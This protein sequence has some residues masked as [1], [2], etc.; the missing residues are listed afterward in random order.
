[1]GA[2]HHVIFK[3]NEGRVIFWEDRD[4][5]EFLKMLK[6]LTRRYRFINH[7]HLLIE[8]AHEP[9]RDYSPGMF[10]ISILFVQG[11]LPCLR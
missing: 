3:G 6:E 1:P 4:R 8:T 5:E 11:W 2:L 9:H 10:I 7:V